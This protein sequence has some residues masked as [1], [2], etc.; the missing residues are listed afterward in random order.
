MK[1]AD[2]SPASSPG[3]ASTISTPK[4]RRSAQ[5]RYIRRRISAQSWESVP[6]A[7]AWTVTTASPASYSPLNRR[8]SSSSAS[9]RSTELSCESSSV[10][11]SSSSAAISAR[12][13]R[14]AT[15]LCSPRN[16]SSRRWARAWA[17]EVRAAASWS[18]Q[19]P[20]L[21][22]SSSSRAASASSPAGSKVVREQGQLLAD[23]GQAGR[24]GLTLRGVGH[25]ARLPGQEAAL[26]QR[27]LAVL[28]R[29]PAED[30][31]VAQLEGPG[32]LVDPG[33]AFV[34]FPVPVT[35]DQRHGAAAAALGPVLVELLQ[36]DRLLDTA[37]RPDP[38]RLD[39]LPQPPARVQL[40]LRVEDR[41]EGVQIP[42]VEGAD[43]LAD[44]VSHAPLGAVALLELFPRP[45][46]AGVV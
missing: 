22:I 46:P 30:L 42:L 3:E 5:R 13:S 8:A 32:H 36:L 28:V 38:R 21:P 24:Y 9:R 19:K 37:R 40:D 33:D 10:A 11:I 12:S 16:I 2:L 41:D 45:A 43:E 17:A 31:A 18:S 44:G 15:S 23:G 6:P 35:Q 4:P 25:G 39:S 14:S 1:V 7:P 34:L 27:L 20:G 29:P 26:P